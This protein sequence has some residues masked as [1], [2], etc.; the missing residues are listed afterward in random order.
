MQSAFPGFERIG[1]MTD[2][3]ADSAPADLN[4]WYVLFLVILVGVGLFLWL[5][6]ETDPVV[7]PVRAEAAQ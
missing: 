4:R 3:R 7:H 1:L 2:E 5:A 6:P